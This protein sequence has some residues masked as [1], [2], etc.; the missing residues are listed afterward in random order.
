M[1]PSRCSSIGDVA[2][3][4][5]ARDIDHFVLG[6]RSGRLEALL[7]EIKR[8][9]DRDRDHHQQRENRVADDHQGMARTARAARRRR[10]A[11]RLDRKP[12]AARRLRFAVAVARTAL[13]PHGRRLARFSVCSRTYV[14][15]HPANAQL[16][17]VT[18]EM[19]A[20]VSKHV[21]ERLWR[22][23]R[24]AHYCGVAAENQR[25]IG[26][27]KAE[28]IRQRDIDV[29]L[30]RLVRHQV[31]RRFDRRIVEID[32]RRGDAVANGQDREDRL[33]R[34]GGAEQMADADLVEDIE[35][36]PAALPTSRCTAPSS[37]S[38]PSGVEV[39]CALM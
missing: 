32:G 3:A 12:R 22:K 21:K 7:A 2:D 27:A 15:L 5:P 33:D 36:P 17:E 25:G 37:I 11:L 35:M 9:A 18:H 20:A 1:T 38:S 23:R 13:R 6:E 28:G 30:A 24:G 8:G 29:A 31:D 34:A 10:H 4:E 19:S 39:P 26:A 16:P 14:R